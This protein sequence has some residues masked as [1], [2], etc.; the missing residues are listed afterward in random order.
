MQFI[1]ALNIRDIDHIQQHLIYLRLNSSDDYASESDSYDYVSGYMSDGEILKNSSSYNSQYM[2]HLHPYR[3]GNGNAVGNGNSGSGSNG[4]GGIGDSGLGGGDDWASGYLSEGGASLYARRL[5]QRFRE[6][7][8][9]VREC[10]QKS[11]SAAMDDDRWVL[12]PSCFLFLMCHF[13]VVT[14]STKISFIIMSATIMVIYT[15]SF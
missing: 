15:V 7:M 6:G 8:Q 1:I 3:A 14:T 10:M 12:L 9:A 2:P 4:N 5:Q 11:S 13:D